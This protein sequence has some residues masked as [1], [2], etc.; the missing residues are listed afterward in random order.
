MKHV[1]SLIICSLLACS[2][3]NLACAAEP[4]VRCGGSFAIVRGDDGTLYGW[5]DGRKGQLGNEK[6]KLVKLPE[7]LSWSFT[8]EISDIQC[9]NENTLILLQDGTVWTCGS[10]SYGQQARTGGNVV[11]PVRIDGL[12]QIVQIASGF[13]HCL[14]LRTD[15]TV[16]AWGR[17]SNGQLGDGKKKNRSTPEIVDLPEITYIACGGKYSLCVTQD[18]SVYGF[19]DNEYG[20]LGRQNGK[21]TVLFPVKLEFPV[22]GDYLIT[23]AAAG[24]DTAYCLDEAGRVWAWGRNDYYQTGV[25]GIGDKVYA[26][27]QMHFP[28][29]IE[30]RSIH[31]YSGHTAIVS[32]DG[33]LIQWGH[34]SNGVRG[35]LSSPFKGLPTIISPDGG[36]VDMDNGSLFVC[37]LLSDGTVMTSGD[38][39]YAQLGVLKWKQGLWSDTGL[40]LITK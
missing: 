29:G 28:D 31:A 18:G 26:P 36:V 30:V 24:G 6:K 20:Q 21:K 1:F 12:S 3:W 7:T 10:N 17:G 33:A 9:G 27:V 5:G 19:G 25:S 38:N 4:F 34:V 32:T 13:G 8:A 2:L 16:Y 37:I 35:C 15:G 11:S 14:A 22:P 23:V 40:R 39:T